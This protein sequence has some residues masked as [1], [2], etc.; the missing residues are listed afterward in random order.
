MLRT[1]IIAL[2]LFPATA[3]ATG[4]DLCEV[5]VAEEVVDEYGGTMS[6]A[7]FQS[8]D[9]FLAGVYDPDIDFSPFIQN[10]KDGDPKGRVRGVNCVRNDLLPTDNDYALLATGV[11]LTLSQDFDSADSD[12]LTMF[13]GPKGFSYR[14][15]SDYPMSEELTA[16]LE[17]TLEGFSERDHGLDARLKPAE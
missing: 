17:A 11:P 8:A 6:V 15:S 1:L 5:V 3:F 16:L 2:I 9:Q 12:L 7:S 14:Y 10:G 13:Y 4:F